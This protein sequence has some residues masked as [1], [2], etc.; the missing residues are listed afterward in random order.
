M[1]AMLAMTEFCDRSRLERRTAWCLATDANLADEVFES[2]AI[3]S[4]CF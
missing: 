4:D 3:A 1:R 2:E